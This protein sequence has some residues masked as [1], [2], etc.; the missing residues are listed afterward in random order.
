MACT[1]YV[2]DSGQAY[3]NEQVLPSLALRLL[4]KS[5]IETFLREINRSVNSFVF[6]STL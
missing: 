3:H 2:C 1:H 6:V 5:L 4:T